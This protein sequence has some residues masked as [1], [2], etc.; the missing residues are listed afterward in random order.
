MTSIY[1]NKGA[2]IYLSVWN[3]KYHL[4]HKQISLHQIRCSLTTYSVSGIY[5]LLLLKDE[6]RLL[7]QFQITENSRLLAGH[8]QTLVLH[9]YTPYWIS[10]MTASLFGLLSLLLLHL[11]TQPHCTS[12][13]GFADSKKPMTDLVSRKLILPRASAPWKKLAP[14]TLCLMDEL[15]D[16]QLRLS[17]TQLSTVN[18]I[19]LTHIWVLRGNHTQRSIEG[20][21]PGSIRFS[22]TSKTEF[23]IS[24]LFLLLSS[25]FCPYLLSYLLFPAHDLVALTALFSMHLFFPKPVLAPPQQPNDLLKPIAACTVQGCNYQAYTPQP[26]QIQFQAAPLILTRVSIIG[27]RLGTLFDW[28]HALGFVIPSHNL[29]QNISSIS[30]PSIWLTLMP[31]R[32]RS[33]ESMLRERRLYCVNCCQ[34]VITETEAAAQVLENRADT[35][36]SLEE[37][38]TVSEPAPENRNLDNVQP[39]MRASSPVNDEENPNQFGSFRPSDEVFLEP[40]HR[41]VPSTVAVSIPHAVSEAGIDGAMGSN[42]RVPSREESGRLTSLGLPKVNM[43]SNTGA[44]LSQT[45]SSLVQKIEVC[46]PVFI[47][48]ISSILYF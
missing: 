16:L 39:R 4:I 19:F 6:I 47:I 1:R 34:W 8:H 29:C 11:C 15:T 14:T 33:F 22:K 32:V 37:A 26:H 27:P 46:G 38:A 40:T 48:V 9:D 10:H 23:S 41:I 42:D 43:P 13:V 20:S 31:C 45:V 12:I 18:R 2:L 28:H 21:T 7:R 44:V 30:I 35:S 36:Q 25:P 5:K 24:T 17:P 3:W